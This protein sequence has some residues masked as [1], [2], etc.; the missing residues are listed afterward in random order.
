MATINGLNIEMEIVGH[1][2]WVIDKGVKGKKHGLSYCKA[3]EYVPPHVVRFDP[4]M[5]EEQRGEQPLS[6]YCPNCG[7][8]MRNGEWDGC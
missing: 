3:C 6:P 8:R 1:S 5:C 7:R 2:Y 4:V